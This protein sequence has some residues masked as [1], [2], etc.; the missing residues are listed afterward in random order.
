M[1]VLFGYTNR[2]G[3]TLIGERHTR[4]AAIDWRVRVYA[5]RYA[6]VAIVGPGCTWQTL[7]TPDCSYALPCLQGEG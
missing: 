4:D 6:H 3:W 2:V 1:F 7:F 5:N